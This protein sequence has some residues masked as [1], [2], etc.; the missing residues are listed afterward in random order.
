MKFRPE[1]DVLQHAA[2]PELPAGA[3]QPHFFA[4]QSTYDLLYTDN[5]PSDSVAIGYSPLAVIK[6][7]QVWHSARATGWSARASS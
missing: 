3:V 5:T 6:P 7:T 4:Q 1:K 2:I